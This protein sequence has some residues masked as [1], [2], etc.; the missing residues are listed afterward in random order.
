AKYKDREMEL[1]TLINRFEQDASADMVSVENLMKFGK[2][3]TEVFRDGTIQ[4]KRMILSCLG[5]NLLLKNRK[6][7]ISLDK[8][9]LLLKEIN[10][11]LKGNEA[12]NST[13][14]PA[15]EPIKKGTYSGFNTINPLV[16]RE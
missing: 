4:Q 7:E 16:L 13:L 15:E 14:E 5:S 9:L 3:A 12:K 8:P 1:R 11:S 10:D 2:A 6:L